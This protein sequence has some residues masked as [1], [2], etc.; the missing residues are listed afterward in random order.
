MI[1][2]KYLKYVFILDFRIHGN[3]HFKGN[4]KAFL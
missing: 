4:L 1:D 3:D 2:F